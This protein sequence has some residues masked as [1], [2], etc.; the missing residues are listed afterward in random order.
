MCGNGRRMRPARPNARPPH[1]HS[2][3]APGARALP[4]RAAALGFDW[5]TVLPG[6]AAV[7]VTSDIQPAAKQ[8]SAWLEGYIL[9]KWEDTSSLCPKESYANVCYTPK[10]AGPTLRRRLLVWGSTFPGSALEMPPTVGPF[11]SLSQSASTSDLCTDP[12]IHHHP[13]PCSL[14]ARSSPFPGCTAGLAYYADWGTLRGT[15]NVAFIATLMAKHGAAG[16]DHACWARSQLQYMVGASPSNDKSFVIGYGEKQAAT[17][18]HHRGAA[19]ARSYA[20]GAVRRANNGTCAADEGPGSGKPCCDAANFMSDRDS[21]IMLK[22][23]LVG[24]P[25]QTDFFPNVRGRAWGALPPRTQRRGRLPSPRPSRRWPC[26]GWCWPCSN[27]MPWPRPHCSLLA[28]AV[29][30]PRLPSTQLPKPAPQ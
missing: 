15:A 13:S 29:G 26:H 5:D 23:A 2:P 12:V 7:L 18:P 3:L 30:M 24:G 25:D 14:P 6:A 11:P 20:A 19:C 8:A 28:V 27:S 21:P 4:S 16:N 1:A 9:A 22:G 10:G 17:R